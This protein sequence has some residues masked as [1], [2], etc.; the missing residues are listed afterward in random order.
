MG[1]SEGKKSLNEGLAALSDLEIYQSEG[2]KSLNEGL[3]VLSDLEIYQ[4][5]A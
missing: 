3:A 2:K 4:S 1:Q 5:E